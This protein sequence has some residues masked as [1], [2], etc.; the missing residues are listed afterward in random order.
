MLI[1]YFPNRILNIKYIKDKSIIFISD[2]ILESGSELS[3]CI[4]QCRNVKILSLKNNFLQKIS[5]EIGKGDYARARS[6]AL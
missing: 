5:P 3:T 6:F 2:S 4:Y 1:K